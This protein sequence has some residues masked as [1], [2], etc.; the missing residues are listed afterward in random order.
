MVSPEVDARNQESNG[1]Y[2][3]STTYSC[4]SSEYSRNEIFD[5]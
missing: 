5:G 3:Q 1:R 2:R 4:V